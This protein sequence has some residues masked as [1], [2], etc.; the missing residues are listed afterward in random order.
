M[1]IYLREY[2]RKRKW[3]KGEGAEEGGQT[4]FDPR[5]LPLNADIMKKIDSGEANEEEVR[6][7]QSDSMEKIERIFADAVL[8]AQDVV[9]IAVEKG[10]K[11]RE[12]L[13]KKY[14]AKMMVKGTV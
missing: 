4:P 2:Q 1:G 5:E 14:I 10:L 13:R 7:L 8:A 11:V 6:R 9:D 12:I 3:E